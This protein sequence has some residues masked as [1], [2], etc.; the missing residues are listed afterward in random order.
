MSGTISDSLLL[1]AVS[2]LA[3]SVAAISGF[4]M[5]SILTPYLLLR[6][7]ASEAIVLVALPHAWATAFRMLRLR[8][9]IHWPTFRQFGLASAVGGLA[10]AFAQGMIG[11]PGLVSL[12]AVLLFLAGTGELRQRSVPL[13][14]GRGWKL[15]GGALSGFFG[16]MLG[17]QGGIRSAALLRFGL[18]PRQIVATATATALLVDGARLPVYLTTAGSIITSEYGA[19]ICMAAGATLGTLL[20]VP[21]LGRIAEV[22]YRRLVGGMLITLAILL[23]IMAA[24]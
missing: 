1:F 17:N 9:D 2:L 15:I 21:V 22:A 19:I 11:G 14:Q 12:L 13:P 8:H 5:G 7:Q 23:L 10:G 3:G 18:T 4:G 16:G 24:I 6:Y 20:G